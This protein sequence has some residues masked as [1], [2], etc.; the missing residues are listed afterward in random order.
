MRCCQTNK[1]K[2]EVK[3]CKTPHRSLADARAPE[4]HGMVYF[5]KIIRKGNYKG[6]FQTDTSIICFYY[7]NTTKHRMVK[8]LGVFF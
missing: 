8:T 5:F 4:R 3:K 1:E 2:E 7:C 6:S